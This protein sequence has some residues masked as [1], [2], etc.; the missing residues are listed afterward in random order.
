MERLLQQKQ[1]LTK[2]NVWHTE[3]TEE[4]G[5]K[6]R[7]LPDKETRITVFPFIDSAYPVSFRFQGGLI[8]DRE[9]HIC[10]N[11]Q[12]LRITFSIPGYPVRTHGE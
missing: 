5:G 3:K 1:K 4:K 9:V 2:L 12:C 7:G 10:K 8:R 6:T 11:H